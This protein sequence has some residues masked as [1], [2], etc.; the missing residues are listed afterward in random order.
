MTGA[1][2]IQGLDFLLSVAV[3]STAISAYHLLALVEG[4]GCGAQLHFSQSQQSPTNSI[5]LT[6]AGVSLLLSCLNLAFG[7]RPYPSLSLE[8]GGCVIWRIRVWIPPYSDSIMF[9]LTTRDPTLHSPLNR[10]W[11]RVQ[12][13]CRDFDPLDC[14]GLWIR[15]RQPPVYR[16]RRNYAT[17]THTTEIP[18]RRTSIYPALGAS[19][20][21]TEASTP[22]LRDLLIVS[23]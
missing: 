8:V 17:V 23:S 10:W 1:R 14:L 7:L 22:G 21:Y 2:Q 4:G 20:S 15:E 9:N 12:L 16:L 13:N 6:K 5:D 18:D 11:F 19:D 3:R